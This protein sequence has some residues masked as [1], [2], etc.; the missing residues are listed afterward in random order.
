MNNEINNQIES[1]N[2][3]KLKNTIHDDL[4]KIRKDYEKN[5]VDPLNI[6]NLNNHLCELK[7]KKVKEIDINELFSIG[8]LL[9]FRIVLIY[10]KLMRIMVLQ[11]FRNCIKI[12]PIFTNK[13]IDAMIPIIICEIFENENNSLFKDRYECMKLLLTWLELSNSNF[14]I[15]FPQAVV[16]IY[17][18]DDQFK[19]G[20]IEFLRI[21]SII[22]PDLCT[23]V[24]GFKILIHSL[25]EENISQ[26]LI[27]KIIYTLIYLMNNPNKRKYFNGLRDFDIFFQFSQQVIFLLAQQII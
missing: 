13:I 19:I 24:G 12:K 10:E 16:S 27:N 9:F 1:Q 25:L 2:I 15:I 23:T 7:L 4:I 22:R 17:N 5:I 20:C 8:Y 26:D 14:P 21:M 11:I 18:Y 6:Y 3:D